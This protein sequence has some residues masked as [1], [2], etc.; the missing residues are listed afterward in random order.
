[1]SV[2]KTYKYTLRPSAEQERAMAVVVRRCRERYNAGLQERRN[3]WQKRGVSI[4]AA[5]QSA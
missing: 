3:A 4:T 2:R 5:S 1:L